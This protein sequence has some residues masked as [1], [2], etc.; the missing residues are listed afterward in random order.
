MSDD[1]IKNNNEEAA[2]D[3]IKKSAADEAFDRLQEL[4]KEDKAA[5][6]AEE[7]EFDEDDLTI[8]DTSDEE[9]EEFEEEETLP[10]TTS[11][12]AVQGAKKIKKKDRKIFPKKK[13]PKIF[14]KA[15]SEKKLK[16]AIIKPIAIPR[17]KAFL[18]DIFVKDGDAKKAGKF[19]VADS[20]LFS[21][22]E[23][24]RLRSLAKDIESRKGRFMLLPFV[25]VIAFIAFLVT[26]FTAIK[27]PLL[28]RVLTQVAQDAVG[29]KV[30]IGS[31]NLK[32][33]GAS[34]TVTDVAVGNK[35]SVMK[36]I[37]Q[38]DKLDLNFNLAQALRGKFDAENLEVSGIALNTDRSVS[39]ELPESEKKKE[40]EKQPIEDTVFVQN[41]KA[42]SQAALTDL[43]NQAV[44]LL[45][46]SDVESIVTNLR[47]QLTSI[48]A[49]KTAE[50]KVEGLVTKWTGKP[51]EVKSQI[52][53]YKASVKK[54]QDIDVKKIS[55]PLVLQ[56]YITTI[57]SIVT[58]TKGLTESAKA[59]KDEILTDAN[60][61]KDLT[62]SI[63]DAVKADKDMLKNR[64]TAIVDTVKNAKKLLNDALETVAYSMLGDYYP[65]IKQGINYAEQLKQNSLVQAAQAEAAKKKAASTEKKEGSN[66]LAGT[67]FWFGDNNP[68]F[69][70]ERAYVSG[71]DFDA[72]IEE[73]TNDQNARNK[74]T[75]VPSFTCWQHG[76]GVALVAGLNPTPHGT[77]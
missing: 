57:N 72:K 56:E 42:G 14:R 26:S 8:G 63:T 71:K 20:A 66:R 49:A 7:E 18:Q 41:L 44:D 22:R 24:A 30:D 60:G 70:I 62:T 74:T 48:E 10:A 37:V 45:G 55:D 9:D 13:L 3:E 68:T 47:S 59:L 40:E 52:E 23:I 69:L 73:I 35:N 17:D 4:P 53:D 19:A 12:T 28:K 33:L 64:L 5:S 61:V 29:A 58:D 54:I 67:T 21:K 43:Q 39:C 77:S 31:V 50:N 15:Y 46:G 36:N 16:R 11:G 51:D 75:K 76:A 25:A 65:Y 38:F 32:V 6:N 34:L 1:I 2:G 27:N